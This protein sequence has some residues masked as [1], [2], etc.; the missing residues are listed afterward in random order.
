MLGSHNGSVSAFLPFILA[1]A[2]VLAVP[3]PNFAVVA[4]ASLG[5]SRGAALAAA[6]GVAAGAS[7]LSAVAVL[8]QTALDQESPFRHAAHLVFAAL[9]LITGWRAVAR[10]LVGPLR[11]DQ[12]RK[13]FKPNYFGLGL[14]TA[15]ANPMSAAFFGSA[16]LDLDHTRGDHPAEAIVGIVFL[17]AIV[18][19][20]IVGLAL[21]V[22]PVRRLYDGC[23]RYVDG[24]IG[25]LLIALAISTGAGALPL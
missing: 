5:A 20:G 12:S 18:W 7:L 1:Y 19:F 3:G 4:R 2:L 14:V 8:G 13:T 21:S 23:W 25:V 6:I 24:G 22:G 10:A 16:I 11:L 17:L 15:V 9:L